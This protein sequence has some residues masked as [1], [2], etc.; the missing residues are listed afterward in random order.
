[1]CHSRTLNNKINRIHERALRIVY[2]DYK[3]NF[4]ELLER[5]HSFTIHERNIQYLA[6]EAYKVK[7]GLSPVIMNDA[8]QF[9]NDSAHGLSS[10]N[11]LQR[12]NIQT[13]H[14]GSESIKE[15]KYGT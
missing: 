7:N 5:D 4:K 9:G 8:F 15:L 14:L 13:A 2:N 12:T 11:H 6:T 10:G 1:M 3:S